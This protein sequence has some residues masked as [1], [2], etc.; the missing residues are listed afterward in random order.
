MCQRR[1]R[2]DLLKLP[3]AICRRVAVSP[4]MD[5]HRVSPDFTADLN[6]VLSRIDKEAHPDAFS[7]KPLDRLLDL[8]LVSNN[9]E[10]ALRRQLFPALRDKAGVI[11][12]KFLGQADHL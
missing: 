1:S 5:L 7:L 11:R 10:A 9:V 4:C 8:P 12:M 6:L 2:D 3:V